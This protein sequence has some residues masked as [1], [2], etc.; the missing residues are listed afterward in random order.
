MRN[1]K[2]I[3]LSLTSPQS[4]QLTIEPGQGN[5][6]IGTRG[7][8][9]DKYDLWVEPNQ[10][11]YWEALNE[12]STPSGYAW[13]RSLYYSGDDLGFIAWS[14]TRP[15]ETLD[16][17]ASLQLVADF[18]TAQI[19]NLR[20]HA[21]ANPLELILGNGVYSL[22]LAG[23]LEHICIKRGGEALD[24]VSFAPSST[25][26]EKPYLLPIYPTLAK[27][28]LLY[29]YVEPLGQAFG[30]RSLLQFPQAQTV[31]LYGHMAQMAS[32][33]ELRDL[34]A[35]ALRYVPDLSGLPTL[36]TWPNLVSF[37]AYQI[38]AA[39]GKKLKA[40]LN[41][42]NKQKKMINP[43]TVTGLRSKNWF[44]TQY[45][46]PFEA[47]EAKSAKI[48]YK[49]YKAC[50]KSIKSAADKVAV[51]TAILQFIYVI[52]QLPDIETVERENAYEAVLQ[53]AESS[54]LDI[55]SEEATAWFNAARDF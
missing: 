6:S 48:A 8:S 20:I 43:N 3:S 5:L 11:I 27:A 1:N 22:Y 18:S 45:G 16:W 42:L 35:L 44:Q 31:N 4:H 15:I 55:S 14:V 54:N 37:I 40:E 33:A 23:Q 39:A 12:L 19:S 10:V 26:A 25:K 38:D 41:V 36:S 13:P 21:G 7:I 34:R 50:L 30:L 24:S 46:I 2:T 47:W 9:K 49:A 32:L 53:L 51:K 17:Q 28:K 52:N 29:I